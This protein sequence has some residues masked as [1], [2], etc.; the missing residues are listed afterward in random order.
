MSAHHPFLGML[1]Y[2]ARHA[3]APSRWWPVPALL[4]VAAV[5][6]I[7]DSPGVIVVVSV[8]A[9]VVGVLAG[10]WRR[11]SR[12]VAQVEEILSAELDRDD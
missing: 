3:R 2:R 8:A 11:C 10:V 4:V 6:A 1:T 12:A 7:A 5:I 9:A